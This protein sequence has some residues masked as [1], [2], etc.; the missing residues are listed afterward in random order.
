MLDFVTSV[1]EARAFCAHGL[2][3]AIVYE[4]ALAGEHFRRLCAIWS[5]AA[6]QLD[7]QSPEYLAAALFAYRDG[8]RESGTMM[9]AANGL[10][11]TQIGELSVFFGKSVVVEATPGAGIGAEIAARGIPERD[12]A[13]CDSCH[14]TGRPEYPRLAGQERH[15]LVRQLELFNEHGEA[16]GGLHAEIMAQAIRRLPNPENGPLEPEEIEALADHYGR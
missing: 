10:S 1:S 16:R 9:A 12:I 13:A 11:D 6:P 3:D 15:Y 5:A 4:A 2:P 7:I 8:T 14:G